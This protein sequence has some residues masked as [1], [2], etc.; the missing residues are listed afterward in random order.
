MAR[1]A[2]EDLLSPILA[3]SLARTRG[4]ENGLLERS[5]DDG[6]AVLRGI[7]ALVFHLRRAGGPRAAAAAAAVFILAVGATRIFLGA[8]WL[9]DVLAGFLVG[10]FWVVIC[11]T[12]TEYFAKR[13]VRHSGV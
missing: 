8:H 4:G 12:G 1:D 7:A 5:R 9:T 13:R 6:D 3:G 11:A 2:A 10:L